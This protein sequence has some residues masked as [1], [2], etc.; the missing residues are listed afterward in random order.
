[1]TGVGRSWG[2]ECGILFQVSNIREELQDDVQKNGAKTTQKC[3]LSI[4]IGRTK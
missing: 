3:D 4:K 1:M 2:K